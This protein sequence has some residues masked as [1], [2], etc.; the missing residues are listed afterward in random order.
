VLALK[1]VDQFPPCPEI[2]LSINAVYGNTPRQRADIAAYFERCAT[3]R[4]RVRFEVELVFDGE[5]SAIGN[6]HGGSGLADDAGVV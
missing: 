2:S 6:S 4:E 3:R 1:P 5:A